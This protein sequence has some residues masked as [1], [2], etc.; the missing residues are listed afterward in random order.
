MIKSDLKVQKLDPTKSSDDSVFRNLLRGL[1]TERKNA[2]DLMIELFNQHDINMTVDL[3]ESWES[4]VGIPDGCF[5]ETTN[6]NLSDRRRQVR[7]KIFMRGTWTKQNY[8]DLANILIPGIKIEISDSSQFFTF[9]LPYP[10]NFSL[11]EEDARYTM[12][13]YLD[14]TLGQGLFPLPFPLPFSSKKANIIECIFN[15]IKPAWCRIVYI[16]TLE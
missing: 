1:S 9:P 7:A 12:Y 11:S 14:K 13:V 10:I 8:I 2:H 5:K 6:L 4:A 3:I 16:Y 15:R